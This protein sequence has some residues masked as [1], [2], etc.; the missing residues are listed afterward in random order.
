MQINN[1]YKVYKF[2]S[3]IIAGA[4]FF[5]LCVHRFACFVDCRKLACRVFLF[6][7]QCCHT[8]VSLGYGSTRKEGEDSRRG[9]ER[10]RGKL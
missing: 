4:I 5:E 6:R 3:N 9:L 10:K 8:D 1:V 7:A 2:S